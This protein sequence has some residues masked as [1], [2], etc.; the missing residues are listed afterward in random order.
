ML[1]PL[2]LSLAFHA[3]RYHPTHKEALSSFLRSKVPK[4]NLPRT[5]PRQ[6]Q[7]IW[8]MD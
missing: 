6:K 8:S 2:T 1:H 3:I 4:K 5:G 7:K